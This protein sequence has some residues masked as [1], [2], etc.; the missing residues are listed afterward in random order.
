MLPDAIDIFSSATV[1]LCYAASA[2][3]DVL[4]LCHFDAADAVIDFFRAAFI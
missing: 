4:M 1:P 3:A 2:D